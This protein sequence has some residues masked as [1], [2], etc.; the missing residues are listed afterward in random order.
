M[1]RVTFIIGIID[2]LDS[3]TVNT[4][5]AAGVIERTDIGIVASLG[6]A[7]TACPVAS[8]RMTASHH[9]V[10]FTAIIILII[11]TVFYSTF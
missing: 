5:C 4:D 3:L 2:T 11:G 10:P 8:I 1:F 7:F 9:D 6:K